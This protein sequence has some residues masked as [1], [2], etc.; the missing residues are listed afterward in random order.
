MLYGHEFV[1]MG[2]GAGYMMGWGW[3]IGWMILW[4]VILIGIVALVVWWA[5]T[6]AR[7][8]PSNHEGPLEILKLRYARGEIDHDEYRKRLEVLRR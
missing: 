4:A 8:S 6:A 3:G 5:S 1:P 2:H 7:T